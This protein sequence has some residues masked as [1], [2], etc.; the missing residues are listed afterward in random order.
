MVVNQCLWQEK[1]KRCFWSSNQ[2]YFVQLSEPIAS[3]GVVRM[4]FGVSKFRWVRHALQ[5]FL[6]R[7][8]VYVLLCR[9][10]QCKN[11][12]LTSNVIGCD[13]FNFFVIF[14]ST[15]LPYKMKAICIHSNNCRIVEPILST[16]HSKRLEQ[17]SQR[18]LSCTRH[19]N[20]RLTCWD[21]T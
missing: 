7:W 2:K 12:G 6:T 17:Q 18:M 13:R 15:I 11:V 21:S 5:G 19:C 3:A 14:V 10:N 1:I 4:T 20:K 8:T 16:V 9:K